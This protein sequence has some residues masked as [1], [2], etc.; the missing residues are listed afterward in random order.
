M[1]DRWVVESTPSTRFP[2]YT[3]ANI[4]EV[5]PDPV[6]PL[7]YSWGMQG[8]DGKLGFSEMGFRN[9][10]VRL[11]AFEHSEFPDDEMV[12]LGVNGGYGY[13][14]ASAMR[15][16]GERAPGLTAGDIDAMFFGEQPGIPPYEVQEG[17]VRPD[18]EAKVGETFGWALTTSSL[19]EV[20]ADE[21]AMNE[22]RANRPDLSAMSDR[23]LLDMVRDLADNRFPHIFGQHIY[24]TMLATVPAGIVTAVCAAV[25]RPTD[26]LKVIAGVGDVE[27]AAPSMAMWDLGRLVAAS[28]SLNA[29]FDGGVDGIVD[30]V[31]GVDGPDGDN[32]REE[33][34][35]FVF[36]Y[37]ARGPNEWEVREPTWEVEPEL[38]LAAID[39]MRLSPAS[40][41]PAGHN[42]ELADE[43]LRLIDEIAAMVE[44]DP[45]TH[46]QFLAGCRAAAVFMPGRERTKTNAVKLAQE[47]RMGLREYGRRM[48]ERGHWEKINDFGLLK[49][50]ELTA[51]LDDPTAHVVELGERRATMAELAELQEPFV[52]VGT[53]TPLAD[54]PRRDAAVVDIAGSG[55][56]LQG[57]PGCAGISRGIARVVLDSHDPSA[58][59]PGDVLVAPITDPSWTPLFVPASGV[60]VDVGAPLSHAIIVSRELGIP[61]VV[62]VTDATKRIPDGALVEVNGETGVITVIDATGGA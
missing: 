51:T 48:V 10:Y 24:I 43:R 15:L 6:A 62:S 7:T 16:F 2:I 35:G 53:P 26:A 25:G 9:A 55:D 60:I 23:E 40:S 33:F 54:Y 52:F 30:R 31:L 57:V 49:I 19:D 21:K 42:K 32:F 58:L 20:L 11:G 8:D 46:G 41:A 37:G 13:L 39:R 38:V 12:F 18:L 50:D 14:N 5:F 34:A 1:V 56:E 27:S 59:E 45:E 4:G 3:R 29:A 44:S 28:E 22:L 17:D 47:I 36:K 61:C